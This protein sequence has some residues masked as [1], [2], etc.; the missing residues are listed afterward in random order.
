MVVK[1]VFVKN[2]EENTYGL[3]RMFFFYLVESRHKNFN[4]S[5]INLN[6]IDGMFNATHGR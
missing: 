1:K 2:F 4:F 3:F 6:L 5:E